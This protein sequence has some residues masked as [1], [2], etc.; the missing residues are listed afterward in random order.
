M[1]DGEESLANIP[2]VEEPLTQPWVTF[3]AQVCQGEVQHWAT[4]FT[5]FRALHHQWEK[6]QRERDDE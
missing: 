1:E 2:W 4:M 5:W 6:N 3:E